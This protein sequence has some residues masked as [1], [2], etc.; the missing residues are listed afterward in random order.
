MGVEENKALVRRFYE[1]M[2]NAG[3]LDVADEVFADD[4]V[5]HDLRPTQ[6]QPGPE[7]QKQ[8][9]AFFRSAFPDLSFVVDL[10]LGEHDLVAARWT[11]SGTHTGPWGGQEPTGEGDE[12]LRWELVSR[13]HRRFRQTPP[14]CDSAAASSSLRKLTVARSIRRTELCRTDLRLCASAALPGSWTRCARRTAT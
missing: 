7:G 2:W 4:Y 10:V 6:A 14:G 5:R 12:L 8:V 9:A 3:D 1:S 11:A 13:A